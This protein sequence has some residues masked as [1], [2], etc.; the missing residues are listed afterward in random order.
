MAI[1]ISEI[2]D[3]HDSRGELTVTSPL[4]V[5]ARG[6]V[7]KGHVRGRSAPHRLLVIGVDAADLVTWAGGLICDSVRAGLGVHVCLESLDGGL[8]LRILGVDARVL[9]DVF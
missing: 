7:L 5:P 9:P 6:R 8:A 4:H 1:L 2:M 3:Y